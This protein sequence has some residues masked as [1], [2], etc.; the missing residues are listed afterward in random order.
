ME[1]AL[2]GTARIPRFASDLRPSKSRTEI[3]DDMQIVK[4]LRW[5]SSR[6]ERRAAN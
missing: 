4:Y 1:F 5:I 3:V 2:R 6:R